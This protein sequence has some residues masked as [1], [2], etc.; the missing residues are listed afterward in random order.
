MPAPIK[1]LLT[2]VLVID[3]AVHTCKSYRVVMENTLP[4]SIGRTVEESAQV[5]TFADPRRRFARRPLGMRAPAKHSSTMIGQLIGC[6][7]GLE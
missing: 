7:P 6:R 2:L 3:M 4:P 5:A 1:L